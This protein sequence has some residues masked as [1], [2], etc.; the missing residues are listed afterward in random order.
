MEYFH[1]VFLALFT[2]SMPISF[3]RSENS[4]SGYAAQTLQTAWNLIEVE[5]V[6]HKNGHTNI[7]FSSL[8]FNDRDMLQ[9]WSEFE[10]IVRYNTTRKKCHSKYCSFNLEIQNFKYIKDNQTQRNQNNTTLFLMSTF[11]ESHLDIYLNEIANRKLSSTALVMVNQLSEC[12]QEIIKDKFDKL[13]MNSM[14]YWIQAVA[15]NQNELVWNR[16]VTI[17]GLEKAIINTIMFGQHKLIKE[18]Y[19]LKGSHLV[20]ISLSWNPYF[21]LYECNVN[22]TGCKSVG[23]LKNMMDSLGELLNFTWECHQEGNNNWGLVQ[24]GIG[25]WDGV[26]GHVFNSTYQLSIR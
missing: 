3:T 10:K 14:F 11:N 15:R 20:S 26:V 25:G 21:M 4:S 24:N 1:M 17:N 5:D 12:Q 16:V 8:D 18:E 2:N 9:I 7:L 6:L 23:Y 13:G 19:N 22:G